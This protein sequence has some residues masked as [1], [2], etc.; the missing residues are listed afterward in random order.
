MQVYL[1]IAE[2]PVNMFV[3]FGMGGAVGFLSGLFG[4]GGGFLLTPLLIF[5]GIPPAVSVATVTTQ[6]VASSASAVVTYWRRKAIDLKLATMLLIGGVLGSLQGVILFDVLQSV[7][8]LDLVI[9]LAYVTFLGAIG[10]L[11]LIESVRAIRRRK[12]GARVTARRPGQHNW[13]HGLPFKMRFRQSKLYVS[14]L[15]ILALGGIIGFLGT[16]LGIGGGFMMVPALIYLLRVPTNIVIGT[17]LL[18]IMFTMAAATIFHSI[19]TQTVDIVLA[20][21]LMIGGVIGAQFGARMG[22]NLRGDQLRLLLALLVL[23]VGMRFAIDL[24]LTP[25]DFYSIAIMKGAGA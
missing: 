13:I 4:I 16:V 20:L 2:I 17:S 9:S 5:S 19:G 6:V 8:Q 7:G 21:T 11:M 10:S 1:P 25:E 15:P 23:L 14:V 22:Q 12:S 24:L 18:Q 3:I